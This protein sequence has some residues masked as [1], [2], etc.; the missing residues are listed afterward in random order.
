M[1]AK[2]LRTATFTATAAFA[3][4]LSAPAHDLGQTSTTAPAPPA[5]GQ[6]TQVGQLVL[7]DAAKA[8]RAKRI[9]ERFERDA[10]VLTVFDRQGK[11]VATIGER[12]LYW[13]PVFS[14]DRTR[15]A[16]QKRDLE[17]E[18]ADV[19][20]L[21]V[22]TG[23][24]KRITASPA[25]EDAWAAVWSPDG[26]ELAYVA[27]RGGYQGLYRKASN[28]SG[29]EELLYQHPGS[30]LWLMNWSM[31]GRFLSFSSTD[32]SGGT[33]YVLPLGTA[34]ERKPMEVFR[35]PSQVRGSS[36]SPDSRFLSHS[37]NESGTHQVYVRRFDSSLGGADAPVDERW[38]ISDEGGQGP[39]FWR[40]DGKEIYYLTDDSSVMV[41]EVSLTP[42]PRFSKP[43]V[44]F[45]VSHAVVVSPATTSVSG[46]GERVVIAVP[47]A[48]TLRQ[49]TVFDRDGQ[50]VS[51]VGEPGRFSD[52]A[53]SPDGTKVAVVRGNLRTGVPDIWTF[54]VASGEGRFI[55]NDAWPDHSP[56]WSPDGTQ[57]AFVSE[58]AG[59]STIRR[60][61][62]DGTG[63]KQQVFQ[64]TPGAF[65]VLTD[66]SADGRFLTFHDGCEGVLH[67]VPLSAGPKA[68]EGTAIEW[69]RDEYSV[70]Q[71]RFSPDTRFMAF[72]SD[73][74][75][76]QTFELYV[77]PFDPSRAD[78]SAGGAKPVR[79]STGGAQG[80]VAWRQDGRELYYL[81]PEWDVMAVDV[82]T[83]GTLRVGPPRRLFKLPTP[84][85]G[86]PRQWRNVS[87]DGQRF[88]FA[89]SVPVSVTAP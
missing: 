13:R 44:L 52:P 60:T 86:D 31:D 11:I 62:W 56:V 57:V 54:D 16:V 12:A 74:L 42:A 15:L 71:A 84:S 35:S 77:R 14:P 38:Q 59:I 80:M 6:P 47:H 85:V 10:R 30:D 27:Q 1:S 24:G 41:A 8:A 20:V 83:T 9:A 2:L 66:W 87:R 32:L 75:E 69:L 26:S 51:T 55:T 76:F 17:S 70:A 46:D 88:V 23:N 64:Y 22:A 3:A 82:T 79:V 89:I 28:G 65:M 63:D 29:T 36:L 58:R 45:R 18:S 50:V 48:P 19:W 68:P 81:T 72:V 7:D 34:G 49:I 5:P 78:V 33:L 4:L 53:L 67:V 25:G 21:D 39:A 61:S 37:S 43:K 40:H 73:E